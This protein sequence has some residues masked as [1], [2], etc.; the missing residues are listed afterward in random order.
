[1][2]EL[3]VEVCGSNGAFYKAIVKDILDEELVISFDHSP[4]NEERV[5]FALARL[6]PPE[7]LRRRECAEGESIEAFSKAAEDL[8]S[9][10]WPA[11]LKM[12]KGEFAV[13]DYVSGSSASDIVSLDKIRPSNVNVPINKDSFYKFSL[14]IPPDLAEACQ[15]ESSITEFKRHCG[16][17]VVSYH[18]HEDALVVLSTL[19]SVIKKASI[20]GDMFLRNLR[21]K[22][23]LK[24][25]TEEAVKKLQSTKI[26]SGYMEEFSVSESLMGLAIGTHGANIQAARKVDGITGIELDESNCTFKVYGENEECVKSARKMLEFAEETFQVPKELVAKVIGKNGRNIQDIVDKSGVVRVKIE[27]DNE[28]EENKSDGQLPFVF[29]GTIESIENAK[30]LLDF[31]LDHLREVEQLRQA[32]QEIDIQLRSM[33]GPNTGPYFPPP[34][35]RR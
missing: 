30:L 9:A 13:I 33:S 25:R 12:L 8:V 20:L 10:W 5:L 6:P 35:E 2:D 24:Q 31:N 16:K 18:S 11:K 27:G 3:V 26:R 32:K 23:L 19:E 34:R 15:E 22:I 29:V 7:S 14:P 21:Q 17:G 1:M 28:A 4:K